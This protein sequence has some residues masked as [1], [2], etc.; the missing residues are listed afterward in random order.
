MLGR[1]KVKSL[2]ALSGAA[3]GTVAA[4]VGIVAVLL[5]GG[6]GTGDRG[7][8]RPEASATGPVGE[9]A[10]VLRKHGA[11]ECKDERDRVE[12]RYRDRYVA[13][14]ILDPKLGLTLRSVL[15]VWKTGAA[16]A[17]TG[18]RAPFA[19]LVGDGWLVTG[20]DAFVEAVRP[21]LS[22][23]IIYCDRPYSTCK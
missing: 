8:V 17:A 14:Q 16:Q 5:D 1:V 13:A 7:T 20:P 2:L 3:V 10:A 15:A 22:G 4:T 21:E 9:I 19:I 18:D 12:C 11:T 6:E 23:R